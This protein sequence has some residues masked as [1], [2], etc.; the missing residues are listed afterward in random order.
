MPSNEPV[1]RHPETDEE[2][3]AC[4]E[5][6]VRSLGFPRE[7]FDMFRDTLDRERALG[8]FVD[9][10]AAAFA[11][12]RPFGLFL[13]GKRVP[14]GGHSPVSTAP[15]FRG[16]G[17]GSMV[18]AGHF[19]DLRER[20]EVIAALYPATTSLYRG[21]G[22]G[23]AGTWNS[24][25]VPS[26]S[27][28]A[29]RPV[30]GVKIR[31]G[32][33][34]DMPGVKDAYRR[35]AQRL[36]GHLDRSDDWWDFL[37]RD[38]DTTTYLYVVDRDDGGIAGYVFYQQSPRPDWGYVISVRELKAD[39]ADTAVALWRLVGSSST[40]APDIHVSGTPE[41]ELFLL[42]NEQDLDETAALRYMVRMIDLPG[43]FA[44]RGYRSG[45]SGTVDFELE[46]RDCPWNSGRWRLSFED[47]NA[48]M[49]KGGDGTVRITP[50]ALATLY[51]GYASATK[52]QMVGAL[53][54]AG[55]REVKVLD[56]AFAGPTPW[57]PEIF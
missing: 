15:E 24:Y 50:A 27:L 9:G 2:V 11:R 55:E 52:L 54:G 20:G 23:I 40:M 6:L 46:D 36:H 3:A 49:A 57:M 22:F 10:T 26:R 38:L 8:V 47:G 48:V 41:N 18:T 30:P 34:D 16:R 39:D 12:I 31:Q 37:V 33:M 43:A 4:F 42:L 5:I 25:K 56:D 28:Q 29:L 21:V 17:F 1:L 53:P 32:S 14:M 13:G 51:S 19:P 35:Q 44:A 45:A 7:R